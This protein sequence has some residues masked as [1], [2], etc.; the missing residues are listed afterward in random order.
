MSTPLNS[1]SPFLSAQAHRSNPEQHRALHPVVSPDSTET[2]AFAGRRVFEEISQTSEPK[3]QDY[4]DP[5]ENLSEQI[6]LSQLDNFEIVEDQYLSQGVQFQNAIALHPSNPAFPAQNSNAIILGGP[7][8][9]T[10]DIVFSPPVHAVESQVTSSGITM[11]TAFDE[12]EQVI[13]SDETLG[14]NLADEQSLYPPH[15]CLLVQH[16]SQAIHRVRLRCGGGQISLSNLRFSRIR[17]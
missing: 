4:D 9:G 5:L 1:Q 2:V 17:S 14:R 8:S 10:I 12:K 16:S 7:K 11:M 6:D 3:F 13:H 15:A